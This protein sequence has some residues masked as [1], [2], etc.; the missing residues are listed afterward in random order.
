V[1]NSKKQEL[2]MIEGMAL[3]RA[4]IVFM[5]LACGRKRRFSWRKIPTKVDLTANRSYQS[6]LD[7]G[8]GEQDF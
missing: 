1:E 2:Q 5:G 8:R 4:M 3:A 6:R 7:N